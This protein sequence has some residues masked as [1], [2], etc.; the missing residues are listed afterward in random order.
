ML[1]GF[2]QT[3]FQGQL[4]RV[5]YIVFTLLLALISEHRQV[6]LEAL[7]DVF[8]LSIK[9]ESRRRKRQRFLVLPQF[10]FGNMW[11]RTIKKLLIERIRESSLDRLEELGVALLDFSSVADL[12][13]WFTQPE[14]REEEATG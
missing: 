3:H 11:F 8:P 9:F 2:Y 6:R 13:A 7:A 4:S 14:R 10:T 1:P 5:Q 12:M